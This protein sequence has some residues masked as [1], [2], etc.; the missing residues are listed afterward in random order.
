MSG[1]RLTTLIFIGMVLGIAVG[2]ACSITWPDPQ[3]AKEIAGYIALVSD[4]FLRLI[5]MIIAPLVFS[6]LVVG[7]AH[8]GDTAAVGRVGGKALLWF[9]GASF[10]SLMLGLVLVNMLQP[11]HNLNLPLPEAGTGTG[12]KAASLSLKEF[13]A[14][15]VPKSAVEAMANNEILQIVVFSIFFGVALAALGEKGQFLAK[16]IEGIADVML[17][18]TGYVMMFAPVAVFAAIAATITTQGIGVLVT[19]G[20][21]MLMFYSGLFCLWILL[22]AVGALLV[23]TGGI[24]RL[25]NLIK[26]PFVLAFS[27]ASSEAAY[28]KLLSN[29]ETFGVPNKITSF[30]LPMGYSFNLDGS[31]MYCTFAVMFIAQAYNIPLTWAQQLTM[32]LLLMVTSKGMAG[33][34][35]ASLVVISATLTQF[36]I[37]EAGLLLIIGIDQFLDMGRSATNVLGNSIATVAVA[38]WEGQLTLSDQRLD[39]VGA[40][41]APAE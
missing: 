30:V 38:K 23:G 35:R 11:G 18:V 6:T 13:V 15:L 33:V 28:P 4:I 17:K 26:E 8:M 24:S 12:L 9:V 22:L 40:A 7:I 20:K 14:H 19:Y 31:M 3:T 32:L 27:T 39:H 1:S 10:C 29:L 2:Y 21:F 5:K 34:P 16:G 37:P 25:V 41:A 36:N